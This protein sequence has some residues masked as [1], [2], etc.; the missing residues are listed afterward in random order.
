MIFKKKKAIL[1]E[2]ELLLDD[3]YKANELIEALRD[4]GC[5][6]NTVNL[7]VIR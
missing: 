7:T 1:M 2:I 6:L 4:S 5:Q 3:Y